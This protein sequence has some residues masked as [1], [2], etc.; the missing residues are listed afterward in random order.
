MYTLF[1]GELDKILRQELL[2]SIVDVP[3]PSTILASHLGSESKESADS[4]TTSPSAPMDT[5][6][7]DTE[8]T[9]L[10]CPEEKSSISTSDDNV[11]SV[12]M[13]DQ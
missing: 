12:E 10:E 7:D 5:S 11:S 6:G 8:S 13:E 9:K 3:S 4:G 2:D 1:V